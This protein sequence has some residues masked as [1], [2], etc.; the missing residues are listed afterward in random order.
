MST[1]VLRERFKETMGNRRQKVKA[2][3]RRRREI[4]NADLKSLLLAAKRRRAAVKVWER[5]EAKF[6]RERQERLSEENT[7]KRKSKETGKG[8][9]GKKEEGGSKGEDKEDGKVT[10]RVSFSEKVLVKEIPGLAQIKTDNTNRRKERK[11]KRIQTLSRRRSSRLHKSSDKNDDQNES[12]WFSSSKDD[13][14]LVPRRARSSLKKTAKVANDED[15]ADLRRTVSTPVPVSSRYASRRSSSSGDSIYASSTASSSMSDPESISIPENAPDSSLSDGV[16][17]SESGD[18]ENDFVQTPNDP[19]AS[20]D[21]KENLTKKHSA[22]HSDADLKQGLVN[23]QQLKPKARSLPATPVKKS[24]ESLPKPHYP[25]RSA[26]TMPTL[27][28]LTTSEPSPESCAENGTRE[29]VESSDHEV[30]SSDHGVENRDGEAESTDEEVESR[31]NEAESSDDDAERLPSSSPVTPET[32]QDQENTFC[33]PSPSIRNAITE[34]ETPSVNGDADI[35]DIFAGLKR[36]RSSGGH[37]P[38]A[39][40]MKSPSGKKA[41]YRKK[42]NEGIKHKN[43]TNGHLRYSS[44]GLRVYT[45]DEIAADQPDGLNG[46]CP[47]ECSCCF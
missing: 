41:M 40:R 14:T 13:A 12:A 25:V 33:S 26:A 32:N 47:F 36:R 17:T 30:E 5:D 15:S 27:S 18:S 38:E 42:G 22:N 34:I 4:A 23:N 28:R 7:S 46:S 44:D 24:P 19:P 9:S 37:S 11:R 20:S 43:F 1:N 31:D 3:L 16:E 39:K 2:A 21:T 10:R 35:D 6:E 45:V 29:E 8:K